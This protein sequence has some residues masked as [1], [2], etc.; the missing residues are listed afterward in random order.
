MSDSDKTGE[1]AQARAAACCCWPSRCRPE[2]AREVLDRRYA[3]GELTR[4]QYETMKG[5]LER[6]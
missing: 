5:D 4:E 2:P 1:S 6:S 3:E